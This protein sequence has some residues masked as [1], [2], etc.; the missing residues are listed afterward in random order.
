MAIKLIFSILLILF[1]TSCSSKNS[2]YDKFGIY[3][4]LDEST[5]NKPI[6]TFNRK[7]LE[8]L[9]YPLIEIQ[10]NGILKQALML[11][12]SQRDNNVNYTSG[13][14]QLITMSGSIVSKTNGMNIDLLSVEVD[15]NSPLLHQKEPKLW[16]TSGYRKHSYL[17]HLN[18]IKNNNFECKFK[19]TDKEKI[20][21][22]EIEYQLT[23]VF[24]SCKNENNSF[25]NIFWVDSNGFVWKSKQWLKEGVIAT[26]SVI[27]PI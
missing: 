27:N 18:G 7:E 8:Y 6:K 24:E 19:I 5:K 17:T 26:V 10:T 15:G 11:P 9:K 1:I 12:L 14:G 23:K 13:S 20:M 4:T 22:V 3:K 25:K 2:I 21:I 16:P